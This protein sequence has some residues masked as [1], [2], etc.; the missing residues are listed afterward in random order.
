MTNPI[1]RDSV[2]YLAGPLF[3]EAERAWWRNTIRQIEQAMPQARPIWPGDLFSNEE[4]SSWGDQAK[5]RIFARCRDHAAKADMIIALL[6]GTM[7]DDGTAWELGYFYAL[8]RGPIYGVRTD[9]R[10]GGD[11]L[12]A[13]VNAM[14]EGCCNAI[15][16][17]I[18]SLLQFLS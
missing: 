1:V 16:P 13:C 7:V 10:N 11:T 15:F 2:I 8:Q 9:F 12:G 3:T 18:K 17:D 6:D 14:I 4:I 5:H